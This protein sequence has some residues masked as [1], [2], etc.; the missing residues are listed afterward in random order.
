MDVTIRRITT[1][2]GELLAYLR[3]SALA[4]AP[5]AFSS[6]H[7]DASRQSA[8]DWTELARRRS[9]GN[10]QTTFFAY[11]GDAPV[12]IV[13]G[14]VQDGSRRADLVS[15]WVAP[16]A[17]RRGVARALIRAVVDWARQAGH[18]ELQLWVTEIITGARALYE[19]S[20]FVATADVDRLRPD[21]PLTERRMRLGFDSR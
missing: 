19:A 1:D 3:L 21:S 17:R 9:A 15:M 2:D 8:E 13:G 14:F 16:A 4:D 12:G 6:T 20:G 11:L 10:R 5:D 7:T 18:D